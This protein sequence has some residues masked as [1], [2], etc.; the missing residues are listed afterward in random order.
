M[1]KRILIVD[2]EPLAL[3]KLSRYLSKSGHEFTVQEANNGVAAIEAI[4]NFKPD[5]IFLDIQMPGLSGFEVLQQFAERPFLVVFQTAFDEFAIQAFEE[6]ACDY[7]LKPFTFDRFQKA[8]SNVL[9]RTID[10]ERLQ[11]LEE[12]LASKEGYLQRLTVKHGSQIKILS[13]QQIACFISKNHY[14]CVYF[15]GKN[16]A[17]TELSLSYLIKRLDPVKF[18]QFHRNNIA[19]VSAISGLSTTREGEMFIDLINGMKL[20]ISR[21]NRSIAKKL[22]L[23]SDE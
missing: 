5:I 19:Q 21:S 16:E 14:T 6:H 9:A 15:D 2:D 11:A 7:L 10:Q 13:T 18:K 23:K 8:L 20:P 17:I 22:I 3:Q 12:K 1:S 4:E